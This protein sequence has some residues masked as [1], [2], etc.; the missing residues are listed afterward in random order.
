MEQIEQLKKLGK[1]FNS[2][3]LVTADDIQEVLSGVLGI[4]A[5]FKKETETINAETK[6][7]V[8][9][10]LDTI[11][12]KYDELDKVAD[13]S[14]LKKKENILS[15]VIDVKEQL[16]AEIETIDK[17]LKEAKDFLNEV[18]AIKV[19]KPKDG[20]DGQSVNK[21]E[22]IA[23]VLSSIELPKYE[24]F[25]LEEKGEQILNEINALPLED[26]YKIDAKRIKN[27]PVGKGSNI[28]KAIHQLS[29]VSLVNLT[30]G[31]TIKYNSTTQLWENGVGG[32]NLTVQDIDGSPLVT[33]VNTIK[34]TNGSVTDDGG[35]VVTVTTGSGGG[36]DVSS[37]TATSVD[38]EV[39]LFSGTGGKT[40]KRA[41]GTG[42][43]KLTSGVLGTASAGT[44]YVAPG[45]ITT[46]GLTMATARLL[47]RTTAS[48]GAVEEITVG[49][50][51][52]LSG[53][54]LSATGGSAVWGAITGTLS[55]QTDLNTALSGKLGTS[56]TSANIFVGNGSNIATGVA[57]SGDATIANTGA[58]TIANQAVTY[59]KIQNVAANTFLANATGSSATVQEIATNR[60]PLF[61]SAI[62]GT[63]SASTFLRGDG[64]WTAPSGSGDVVGPASATDNALVRYDGTTGK[65][66]QNST[67]TLSDTGAL[68][69]L[70][71]VIGV[72]G[73][74]T[75]TTVSN[76]DITIDPHGSGTTTVTAGSGG[77]DITTTASNANITLTPHGSGI[78]VLSNAQVSS[79]TASKVVFTDAS[80]NL[81]STG[82]GTSSQFIKGDGSLDSSTYLTAN[83]T[84]T[85]SGDVTGSGTTSITT[86]IAT[87]AVDLSM[88]SATGTPSASTY[89][90]GDNTWATVS[91]SGDVVGPASAVNNRVVFFDGTTGK[92]IKDSG[93]T[94]SGSNT[95]DQT[96]T[97]TGDVTGSGTGSFAATIANNAVSDAKF[98]Q[99]GA[100]SVVGRSA[101]STGNVADI[102]AGTNHHVLRRSG[103]T[104]GFGSLDLSQSG[105]VGT[106]RLAYANIAQGSARSVL[107]V[108]GNA[109]ANVASIQGTADQVLR[110]DSAGTGLAFGAI[111]LASS[112]AVTG[113]LPVANLNSGTGA[114]AST[115]WR[116]DGTW[117]TPA[118]A[119]TVTS[120]AMTVP[121]GLTISG[122]PITTSGTLAVALDSGYVIP[123]QSTLD[124]KADK[125]G[126]LTQFVGN[127]TW[128]VFYTDNLGDVQELALGASGTYLKSNGA[129]SA[130]S[131]DTPSGSGTV[132]N[133]GTLTSNAVVLGNGTSD[134]KVVTGITTDGTSRISLGVNATTAGSLQLFGGT[135]GNAIIQTP[136]VAG[137]TTITLPGAT[138]TLATLAGSEALTNKSVN[139]VTLV[140]GGSST[141]YLSEDGT[142]TTPAGG[143]GSVTAGTNIAV[144][145]STVS[146]L[147]A[148]IS[149][150]QLTADQNNWSPTGWGNDIS[151]IRV[152]GD[153]G[154]RMIT[155]LVAGAT[156]QIVELRNVGDNPV[157]LVT[158]SA[159]STAANTFDF[160]EEDVVI[161]PDQS[162]TIVYDGT[163]SRWKLYGSYSVWANEGKFVSRFQDD[164][165]SNSASSTI[166]SSILGR[167]VGNGSATNES[168]G[169]ANF[170]NRGGVVTLAHGTSVAN[171][172]SYYS[173]DNIVITND[174][175]SRNNYMMFEASIRT[176]AN[177]SDATNRYILYAGLMDS[178]TGNPA[179]GVFAVYSDDINSGQWVMRAAD[180]ASPTDV[181]T[182]VAVAINTWYRIKIC[183]YPDRTARMFINGTLSA[184]SG[185]SFTPTVG[186]DYGLAIN[187]RKTAGTLNRSFSA[188][189]L[190]YG[191]VY[192]SAR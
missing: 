6:E 126:G 180:T 140:S 147:T 97:L 22:V 183:V 163:D 107:G 89:L 187:I 132:T 81:T 168:T 144:S 141:K 117:A 150:S 44:D 37:N 184:T 166:H 10:I 70:T 52:S 138:G 121:T 114:S 94:L 65:L 145:G 28:S 192:N 80:K 88:L 191:A 63:P 62:T 47:G 41:T 188:D 170:R 46:S 38:G 8:L 177:L 68:A 160:G 55:D 154:L 61:A 71:D 105:T 119:G 19:K 158:Q 7:V 83:Q 102:S 13:D 43:A 15:D 1:I 18:K 69:G 137:T 131:F 50:G 53:G 49:T 130:P 123:L 124:N 100:L 152:D 186:R 58:L 156:N 111:N 67:A 39:A 3:K 136:A 190:G 127:N 85:L 151:V 189:Y 129:S 99:S 90:R 173:S 171:R 101:N 172:M 149:P 42:L 14:I 76:G 31:D 112:S 133:T 33:N 79:L 93:L 26:E 36:G 9:S 24:V 48:T 17:K 35:G 78:N 113:N 122:S 139:G 157:L 25:S 142:Y 104:L 153:S 146:A 109:T 182:T 155:G 128:K 165:W 96:I 21:D 16:N 11:Q 116:G 5:K 164:L 175:G 72:S 23:D 103:T 110:V 120:V 178:V 54:T 167:L 40:I 134:V 179:D 98:R 148:T 118:G 185:A 32:A 45:A 162:V 106:S 91:G 73:G 95:G 57:M 77:V 82:I 108:T 12:D 176:G 181:N 34:F 27:L 59:A 125:S 169:G 29:D 143:G 51:L 161:L 66:I 74:L 159:S 4:L 60:I 75:I 84:I 92:L 135:S 20:K 87:G 64:V 174:N 56:L 30:N 86:T 115:F 2:D